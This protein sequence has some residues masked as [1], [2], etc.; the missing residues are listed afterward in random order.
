MT[1]FEVSELIGFVAGACSTL[2]FLPQVIKVWRTKSTGDISLWMYVVLCTG[3][4]LWSLYGALIGSPSVVITNLF[5]LSL[6]LTIL[7]MKLQCEKRKT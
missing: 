1:T 2:A 3:G 5:I 4:A 7:V 6:S